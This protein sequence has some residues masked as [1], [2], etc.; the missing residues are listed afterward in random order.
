MLQLAESDLSA[1]LETVHAIGEETAGRE[2]FMQA[3]VKRLPGLI[4]SDLTHVSVC[5]LDSGRRHVVSDVP[6]AIAARDLE[7]FNRHFKVNPLVLEHGRNAQARTRRISDLRSQRDFRDSPLYDEYYRSVRIDYVMALPV[8]VQGAEL[9]SFVFNRQDRDFS[10]RDRACA[11]A[12]RP[13]LG[14]IYR[15]ARALDDARAAWGVPATR[16]QAPSRDAM[17]TCR[18]REV[19]RWLS[20]G[21]TDRDI[22]DILEISPRTVHKHLQR[23]YEKLGVETRTAAVVRALRS[24]T[25]LT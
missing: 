19:L 4:A 25:C 16:G 24:N 2:D 7:A 5:D 14:D 6:G 11:E 18:E 12:V 13:L 9:V 15:M 22:G 21:K 20:A 23:I 17:L 8:H 1:C 3:G 10:D